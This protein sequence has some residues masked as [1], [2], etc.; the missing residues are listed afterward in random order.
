MLSDYI[1][2]LIHLVPKTYYSSFQIFE[3]IQLKLIAMKTA[4]LSKNNSSIGK[5]KV[6][7]IVHEYLV[8]LMLL[9]RW[10]ENSQEITFMLP[11][12]CF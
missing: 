11:E 1:F 8:T 7:W 5:L 2:G 12:A 3:C 6:P 9:L 4:E 10:S